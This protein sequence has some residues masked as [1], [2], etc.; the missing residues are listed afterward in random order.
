M[1]ANLTRADKVLHA[2][3]RSIFQALI[4]GQ[5]DV[6]ITDRIEVRLQTRLHEGV[7]CATM[8]K[9]FNR[10]EKAYLLPRDEP[11]RA[12]VDEW[13]GRMLAEGQL[14]RA[15]ARHLGED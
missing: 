7:L 3:N 5:A 4:D 1:D 14:Q 15:I 11:W 10:Q 9:N 12:F 8:P 13:V 2:D 6:M